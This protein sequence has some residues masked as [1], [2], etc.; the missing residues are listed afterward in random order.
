MTSVNIGTAPDVLVSFVPDDILMV[1]IGFNGAAYF[2][3]RGI[4][5]A[6][7]VPAVNGT[8]LTLFSSD[9]K[10]GNSRVTLYAVA[11]VSTTANVSI[12]TQG[13]L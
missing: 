1:V 12:I 3:E 13:G 7:G 8:I 4:S 6:S 11:S 10:Q 9:F 5:V 2:G